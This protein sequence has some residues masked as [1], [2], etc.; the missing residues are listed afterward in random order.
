LTKPSRLQIDLPN[1]ESTEELGRR[2]ASLVSSKCIV[3]LVG[4]LGAGKTTFAKGFAEGLGIR[5]VVS[6]PTFTMLNEYTTGKLP[7]YHLDLYRVRESDNPS[8]LAS[9]AYLEWMQ[10]ELDEIIDS[11]GVILIEWADFMNAWMAHQDRISV[12]LNYST[13][14]IS[15]ADDNLE[16]GEIGRK[17]RISA[18]GETSTRIV[19]ALSKI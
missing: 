9:D 12:E 5:E 14:D 15:T 7:L 13:N 1:A 11:D 2:L 17:A 19:D 3:A 10:A 4:P 6:S 8:S 16:S 18:V